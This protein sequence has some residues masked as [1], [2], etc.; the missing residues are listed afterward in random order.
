MIVFQGSFHG[1]TAQTMAMT[2]SKTIYRAGYQPLPGGVFVAPYPYSYRLRH[3]R[4]RRRPITAS[5]SL[6]TLLK[7]QTAPEETAAIVIEPVLGEGGY[8]PAPVRFLQELRDLCDHYGIMYVIDEVQTGFGRT[9]QDV[10]LRARR[11]HAGHPDHG[12]GAGQRRADL[13]DWRVAGADGEVDARIARRDVWRQR[14]G[15]GGG[16]GDDRRAC[17]TKICPATP[18]ASGS[19]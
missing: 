6:H 18:R 8:V 12:E 1:R 19:T 4:R 13:G 17:A 7:S 3:G 2:T 11:D 5:S 9:G 15:S 14:A 16:R 10:R